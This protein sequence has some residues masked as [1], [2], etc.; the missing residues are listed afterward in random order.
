LSPIP[1]H[2][3]DRSRR[4]RALVLVA[5]AGALGL[6]AAA[7][8][9][10]HRSARPAATSTSLPAAT[11]TTEPPPQYAASPY[12]W[13]RATSPA[14]AVGGGRSATLSAVLA[15]Q[16][17]G[18]WSVF[19]TR[20]DAS[21]TPSATMWSSPD[22]MGWTA[23]PLAGAGASGA[24]GG[25]ARGGA[26]G[27]G[28]SQAVAAAQY[29]AATVVVGSIGEGADQ[30]ATVWLSPSAGAPY[31]TQSVPLSTGPS[32]M[33][34]VTAGS[35]GMFA[36][37]TVDGR[38][39]L[40]SSTNGR[41]WS[42]L[43]GAEK[44]IDASPGGRVNALLAS[45][46]LVFAAGSMQPGAS[47]QAALWS[48]SDG[49]NWHLVSSAAPSFSGPGG[50]IIY[51]LAP[52]D[53]GLVAVGAINTGTGWEPASWISP[54]G[55]SWS[56]PSVDFP[57]ES[58]GGPATVGPSAGTAARS[59]SAVPTFA[60]PAAVVAAGGGTSGQDAWASSDGLHWASLQLP[61]A[62][63]AATS[64]RA[65]VAAATLTTT[66]VLDAE[67]G[68]PY[69][70]SYLKPSGPAAAG[71]SGWTQ[72][73]ANPA[74]FGPIRPEAVPV[75]LQAVAGRLDLTVDVVNRPQTIGPARVASQVL[76]SADGS[77]W[78]PSGAGTVTGDPPTLPVAG[79]LATHLPTGWIAVAS[80]PG[81]G[82]EAWTS[83]TGLVWKKTALLS[84]P[85]APG[86]AAERATISGLCEDRLAPAAAA[87]TTP[88]P[89]GIP[90]P[91]R[92]IAVAVG[93]ASVTTTAAGDGS[94]GPTVLTTRAATPWSSSTGTT[95]KDGAVSSGPPPGAAQSMSGCVTAGPTLVAFG[96]GTTPSG[97]PQ[98]AVWRS[99]DGV[100]WTRVPVT[101]FSAGSANPLVSLATNGGYWLAAADPD[102]GADPLVPGVLGA[103]GR[104]ASAATDAGVGPAPSIE[105]GRVGLWL[106]T[107]SGSVWQAIDTATSP[108]LAAQRTTL[109]L[110]GFAAHPA[111]PTGTA[112][113]AG[114][115]VHASATTL[116]GS[117]STPTT[118][119]PGASA[120]PVVVGVVDGQLAVWSGT[121][122]GAGGGG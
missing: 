37:G 6:V 10:T 5:A 107:N 1:P 115:A 43:A 11:T 99:G 19:G 113:S 29:K 90:A 94:T 14:L 9:P 114:S 59:V 92:Y 67:P 26:S 4:P 17:T 44:V 88:S 84:V 28:P 33:S 73:S 41:T 39:A 24:A 78:T 121:L 97:A 21:G 32:V 69:L 60:G 117:T 122:A 23:S 55:Q 65:E 100:S 105:D 119:P 48:T 96:T 87:G 47:P 81:A 64:W 89:N 79:A 102:P 45:G 116:P 118:L 85:T 120:T 71:G 104:A 72:P 18:S 111:L 95:W 53:T 101:A 91:A 80:P 83:T 34:L 49:L 36:T 50:R 52:L 70:L 13:D 51:S 58:S 98:P 57:L 76:T 74:T 75:S 8:S 103:A 22:A 66:V 7:C 62:D 2:P 46:D 31:T 68:Q 12:D 110:V 38:F 77:S 16:I 3:A 27:G 25:P 112:G 30:Q 63:A 82:P 109:D 106:S 86:V 54:D 20:L 93:S 40:W 108:W 56:L 35:L 42:E 15:P 61:A